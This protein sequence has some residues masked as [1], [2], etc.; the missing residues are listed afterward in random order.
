LIGDKIIKIPVPQNTKLFLS[1]EHTMQIQKQLIP[2]I[3][4]LLT[5][6]ACDF[7]QRSAPFSL[8]LRWDPTHNQ[9]PETILKAL[10]KRAEYL[11]LHIAEARVDPVNQT[12]SLKV[13]I[14][15]KSK[16]VDSVM[17]QQ[18]R[19]LLTWESGFG[20]YTAYKMYDVAGLLDTME[21]QSDLAKHLTINR[22]DLEIARIGTADNLQKAQQAVAILQQ[23]RWYQNRPFVQ[24][25]YGPDA[26]FVAG[27]QDVY[28]LGIRPVIQ[29]SDI[30]KAEVIP[31][32]G[33]WSVRLQFTPAGGRTFAYLTRSVSE[34]HGSVAF[35][36]NKTVYSAPNVM[37]AIEGGAAQFGIFQRKEDALI[38][39]YQLNTPPLPCRLR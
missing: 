22:L 26:T 3:I 32:N 4:A 25:F 1:P 29:Q 28:A 17:I 7:T 24:W 19:N 8:T 16:E 36:H 12:V 5:I 18:T 21:R 35:V 31:S 23:Q 27:T 20:I 15:G 33:Q 6:S 30:E 37:N 34:K 2:L 10:K 14:A 9:D 11:E 39:A 13:Q 38:V